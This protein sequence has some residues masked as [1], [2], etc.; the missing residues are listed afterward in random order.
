M[1]AMRYPLTFRALLSGL[2]LGVVFSFIAIYLY[3]KVGIIALGG[4]FLIGYLILSVTGGYDAKENAMILTI[5][6]ACMLTAMG[7][8]DPII[9][10][11]VYKDYVTSEVIID[12]PLLISLVLP[13]ILLGIFVLYPMHREFVELRWPMVTPMAYMVKV[14][15]KTGSKELRY[16]L[17]GMA[18]S[19]ITSASLMFS[20][21]YQIDL[22]G[23]KGNGRSLSF[24]SVFFSPLYASIGFFISYLG[25]IFIMIGV[26]YSMIVWFF[27]EGASPTVT[28]Q[29]HFFNPYIYS[30]AI[31]MMITT[32]ILTLISYGRKLRRTLSAMGGESQKMRLMSIAALCYLPVISYVLLSISRSLP[33]ARLLEVV[34]IIIV[35]LPIVFISA[36]FAVRAAG[37]T[38]FSSS[39]TLDAVLIITLL[40]F[41]PSFESIMIA[42][43]IIGVFESVAI[44]LIR[45]IKF[46][47]IIGVGSREVLEAVLVGGLIG[48]LFGPWIFLVIHNYQGG[49]GSSL[50]PAPMA[51]LLGGYVLLFYIGIKKRQLPPMIKPELL[52]ISVILTVA[53]WYALQRKGIKQ[54][55]PILI[56]IGM[57]I[58]P[59]FLWVAAIGALIDYRLLQ[60]YG[61]DAKAYGQERAKWN[62]ILSGVMSGEGLVIFALTLLSII[63][64]IVGLP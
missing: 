29:Q 34:E 63:P 31:P 33:T 57:V 40:L 39:F 46:C 14:L 24:T 49:I 19:S 42:F 32:A 61:K 51:K 48:S 25:Y 5:V 28:V 2:L 6:G 4:V 30:V 36:I 18:F 21:L 37:E 52:I 60:K 58:P 26:A 45:R 41:A 9:A 50:W 12:L 44:S 10:L 64:L 22:S 23:G 1:V 59:S 43:A 54:L 53:I 38:G 20:G 16:A 27:L 55:S 47:S 7:F 62:A 35:A 8:I 3:L 15:E 13:G 17:K 56:A 11:I